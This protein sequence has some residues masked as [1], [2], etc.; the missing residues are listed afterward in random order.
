MILVLKLRSVAADGVDPVLN[1]LANSGA[2][3]KSGDMG[4]P[5]RFINFICAQILS[6]NSFLFIDSCAIL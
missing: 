3:D 4:L 6:N 2:F 1:S 5:P